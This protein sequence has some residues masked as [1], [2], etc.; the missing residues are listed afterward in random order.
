MSQQ[1]QFMLLILVCM[2]CTTPVVDA[3]PNIIL[4][5]V[6]DLGWNDLGVQGSRYYETP[7]IDHL[8]TQ[9]MRFTDAYANAPNCAP[10]RAALLSGQYAPRT[11]IYTVGAA[12]RGPTEIRALVPVA[13]QTEL[14]L[15]VVTLAETLAEAGYATGHA[16]KWHLGGEGFLP[17]DHG[18]EWSIAGDEQ[19]SPPNYFYPYKRGQ[20][21]LRDLEEGREDEY[22]A[23]RLVDESV[24]FIQREANNPFF[25]YLSHYS[26]HTPI[27]GKPGIAARYA[28]K[29]GVD[30]QD[31]P[32][33]AAMVQSVDEGVGR[34]IDTLDQLG[35]TENTVLIFYSDNGGFGP[36][37]SMVPLRG[38]KGMLYEGGIR[39]PLIVRWPGYVEPGSVTTESIIG[40]DFYPTLAE[41]A[42]V[43]LRSD[44][45]LD[46]S[47]F[48]PVLT[49]TGEIQSRD[50]IWHFPAYLEADRSVS[51][52]WRTTPASAIRRGSYKLIYFF[53]EGRSEL[54]DLTKDVSESDDLSLR[55]PEV[56]AEL[57]TA[58]M[59]WWEET[60]AFIPSEPNPFYNPSG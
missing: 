7:N 53:E 25:L 11:G 22:L 13:N 26:V 49:E 43:T 47:S 52:P 1:L 40:T 27:Q 2:G 41:I 36:A 3:S 35:L 55:M 32:T 42:G 6:D 10:S 48:L 4:I 20:R 8:A 46:G 12:D 34:I 5:Y 51:G 21:F 33:Y 44:H 59:V 28:D 31:N 19:G 16:G 17:V 54:Y 9:G 29:A 23:D 58:L 37:T 39:V 50:L 57:L 18:F 30:G 24:L 56:T 15:D 14:S 60:Q 45:I 38:S